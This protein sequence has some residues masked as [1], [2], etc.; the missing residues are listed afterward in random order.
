MVQW[1]DL[2]IIGTVPDAQMALAQAFQANGFTVQWMDP[3]RGKA[4]RGSKGMNVAFGAMAQYYEQD[5]QIMVAPDQSIIVRLVKSTTG[6]M[7]GAIGA[8]SVQD[9]YNE[10][11]RPITCFFQQRG[12]FRG[13]TSS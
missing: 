4:T 12:I 7:G 5:F 8:M 1:T 13:A 2:Y 3:Y 11:V 9:K 6:W 10:V